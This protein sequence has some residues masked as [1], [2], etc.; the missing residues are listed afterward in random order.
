MSDGA[1][2]LPPVI[3][4][5]IRSNFY[6]ILTKIDNIGFYFESGGIN[7]RDQLSRYFIRMAFLCTGV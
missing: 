3:V 2:P 4:P 6:S 7:W 1:N 5:L